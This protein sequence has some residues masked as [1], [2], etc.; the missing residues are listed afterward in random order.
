MRSDLELMAK[1]GGGL[2]RFRTV[3]VTGLAMKSNPVSA[4]ARAKKEKAL[5]IALVA[6]AAAAAVAYAGYFAYRAFFSGSAAPQPQQ[7]A[8]SGTASAG[9]ASATQSNAAAAATR[10]ATS[11]PIAQGA[12]SAASSTPGV[13]FKK[14]ADQVLTLMLGVGGTVTSAADLQT[15]NQKLS[16]LLATANKS[17]NFIEIDAKGAD[18]RDLSIG[19]ILSQAN[20]E[21]IDPTLLA[22]NFDPAAAF[23]AYRD[24]NGF[25]PGYVLSLQAGRNW[26]FLENDVA[27][28]ESS[29]N[30]ANLFMQDVGAPS[31]SG[32]MDGTVASTSVRVLPFPSANPSASFVYG[33]YGGTHLIVSASLAGFAQAVSHL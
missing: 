18:G 27:K 29:P 17:S 2:P 13:L 11:N 21:I 26:L 16:V 9:V 24:K 12:S 33:W 8:Q 3:K 30:I 19:E 7:S 10:V 31:T 20:A 23:F 6:I 5:I 25:W 15:F 14:P 1:S 32:F 4:A 28:L 22:A